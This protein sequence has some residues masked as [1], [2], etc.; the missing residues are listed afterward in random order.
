MRWARFVKDWNAT[1]LRRPQTVVSTF[2]ASQSSTWMVLYGGVTYVLPAGLLAP[3][4]ARELVPG[5]EL[6]Q[7]PEREPPSGPGPKKL[8]IM[9]LGVLAAYRRRG[10]ASKLLKKMLE[11]V[12][13]ASRNWTQM[14]HLLSV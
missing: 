8:Y 11:N 5:R 2:L 7:G 13:S 3:E 14:L 10:I 6:G 12:G 1:L 4:L 9:T